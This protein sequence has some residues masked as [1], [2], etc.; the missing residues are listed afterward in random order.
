MKVFGR[1]S[2]YYDLLYRDKDYEKEAGYVDRL[3]K[4][5]AG[6]DSRTLLDIGCGTGRHGMKF[7]DKGY[8]VFGID[9]S[10][11]MVRIARTAAASLG[12]EIDFH[13]S[14][15]TRFNLNKK[16]DIAVALFH[17]MSYQID[18]NS[19]LGTLKNT[20]KH[21]KK[22]GLFIF[23]FWYG[24]AVL[25]RKPRLATKIIK[26]GERLIKRTAVPKLDANT[27][28]VSV[29]YEMSVKDKKNAS[30]EKFNEYHVMRYLFLPELRLMLDIAGF[31]VMK[32]LKWMCSKKKLSED[33]W[34]GLI[35]AGK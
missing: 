8:K 6:R 3:I 25:N 14:D 9:K 11:E 13:V 29:H 2:R 4:R 24:P 12:K 28:T 33:S 21:L 20:H 26:D 15:S 5:Y 10:S 35:I 18:N 17:V 30:A 22:G 31:K 34:N 16:F 32:C 19:L 7:A 27:D 1:Y 23:D